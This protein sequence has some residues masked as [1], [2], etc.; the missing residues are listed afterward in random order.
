MAKVARV[1]DLFRI[2]ARLRC[3][4]WEVK[5]VKQ[6]STVAQKLVDPNRPGDFNQVTNFI[7]SLHLQIFCNAKD[8]TL[9]S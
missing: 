4:D 3:L 5:S 8:R 2:L 6:Y 1:F 9:V 7:P